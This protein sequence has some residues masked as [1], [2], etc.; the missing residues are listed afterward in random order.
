MS[1]NDH[2]TP[3]HRRIAIGL[4]SVAGGLL[5][6][7]LLPMTT[8]ATAHASVEGDLD[9]FEDLGFTDGRTLD[10]LLT[11]TVAAQLDGIVD[12]LNISISY[13]GITLLQ[14]GSAAAD[15]GRL[16]DLAIAIGP[17]SIAN[18][19]ISDIP[20]WFDVAYANGANSIAASGLGN[21][22]DAYATGTNSVANA[23]GTADNLS[24]F[25]LAEAV[26]NVTSA[27][28]GTQASQIP[29]GY[30][31]A[32][33]FDAT[34]SDPTIALA[35]QGFADLAAAF[36]SGSLAEAGLPG[37]FDIGAA[38]S[39]GATSTAATGGNFLFDIVP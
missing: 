28:A 18:A 33:A 15:S 37:S 8:M 21:F 5:A 6:A 30:D 9:P 12:N 14:L 27:I 31:T 22:N 10:L 2:I 17:H 24:S 35:T 39:D 3:L 26:G 36:G 19:G 20:G 29:S 4:G 11:P 16:G 7:A 32:F 13:N 23:G 1:H 25:N 38:L 34:G